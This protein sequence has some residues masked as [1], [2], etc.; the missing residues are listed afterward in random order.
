MVSLGIGIVTAA[1]AG[2]VAL[3]QKL[4]NSSKD[5]YDKMK[6]DA[7]D[8]YDMEQE[9]I[10]EL[11]TKKEREWEVDKARGE[12]ELDIL[13][14]KYT[15]Y[16]NQ[17]EIWK[18]LRGEAQEF[19]EANK[20]MKGM[21]RGDIF[22]PLP[23]G[24]ILGVG[25]KSIIEMQAALEKMAENGNKYFKTW[26][27]EIS[28]N[29]RQ[30]F[31]DVDKAAKKAF[32]NIKERGIKTFSDIYWVVEN[33][34]NALAYEAHAYELDPLGGIENDVKVEAEGI[35][36][37]ARDFNKS[38]IQLEN[39]SYKQRKEALEKAG[40]DTEALT[41]AHNK[42]VYQIITAATQSIL[43]AAKAA[44][45][46]ELDNLKDKYN[47]ELKILKQYGR[48]TTDLTNAYEKQK[49]QII[50]N[51]DV[52]NLENKIKFTEEEIAEYKKTYDELNAMGMDRAADAA[53][54]Q[55]QEHNITRKNLQDA[56]DE[57]EKL[58]KQYYEDQKLTEEQRLSIKEK[59][60]NAKKALEKEDTEYLL[61]QIK[62]R[63][64]AL[65]EEIATIEKNYNNVAKMQ[66]LNTEHKYA[67]NSGFGDTFWG[68]R[69]HAS[70]EQQKTDLNE[71]YGIDKARL[72]E[73][74]DAY[75]EYIDKIAKTDA[76]RTYAQQQQAEKRMELVQL[77]RENLID[78]LNIEIDKNHELINTI[79]D[80]GNSI[81]DIL[82]TVA[83]AWEDSIQAQVDAGKMSQEEA[84]KQMENVRA[85]QIVQATINMLAG[86]FG[87]FAQ[88][89]ET[90]PPPYGQIVGAAAA[91]AVIAQGIAQIAAIRNAS[92]KSSGVS[93]QMAQVT[94]VMTDYQP[95]MVGT[96]TGEQETEQLT[97]ALSGVNLWVSVTDI[98]NAQ[99]RGRVKVTESTF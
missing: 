12:E 66:S 34:R 46:T 37:E 5:A 51:N 59:Y 55:E 6:Q 10:E 90:I 39:D 98:D 61:K 78:N 4:A 26:K 23:E 44:N 38:E 50:F 89:S 71:S 22:F 60:L 68:A 14:K 86:S 76:E 29:G 41:R 77:E 99:E 43:D 20:M 15:E 81:G 32:E 8:R 84:D 85:L 7:L 64:D 16:S 47:K 62:T 87:A 42:R 70:F 69:Q 49:Q 35:L 91:A 19:L 1:I 2:L 58:Y 56:L 3:I 88:A 74:I 45:Q 36:K 80:V 27:K 79:V 92:K 73:E 72:Q 13:K 30:G 83:D 63:K 28:V 25:G 53:T 97:N 48:D 24:N 96:A 93:T 75:Q 40:Y 82:G 9:W 57:W 33:Y 18:K 21:T 31:E 95:Q 54:I 11:H 17:L 94:P 65:D 52:K 67:K